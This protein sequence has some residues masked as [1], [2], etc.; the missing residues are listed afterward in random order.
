M[1]STTHAMQDQTLECQGDI[2]MVTG[3]RGRRL[4]GHME[5]TNLRS[6]QGY[7]VASS[8]IKRGLVIEGG[9]RFSV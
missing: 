4:L 8:L 1:T 7:V 2:R 3:V 9:W 5:G 6:G